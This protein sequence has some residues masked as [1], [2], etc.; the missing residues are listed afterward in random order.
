[1]FCEKYADWGILYL[2]DELEPDA[3]HALEAHL[4]TC[5]QCQVELA[6]LK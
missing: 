1:M 6:L 4:K 5:Q 2:Y 3:K